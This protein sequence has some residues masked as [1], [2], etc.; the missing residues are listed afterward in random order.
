MFEVADGRAGATLQA[1][2]ATY[3]RLGA[4]WD[5]NRVARAAREHRVSMPARHRRGRPSY[6]STLS[7][8][9]RE[10]AELAATGRT[11]KEIAADLFLSVNT[12]SRHV[13]AVMRKLGIHSRAGISHRL[14][15]RE[16]G[17]RG[18]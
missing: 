4:T 16:P 3:R 14:A 15:G 2:M 8:R 17:G 11:N 18:G 13:T 12:V 1:A 7:P 5:A 10:V 6:G 9:E